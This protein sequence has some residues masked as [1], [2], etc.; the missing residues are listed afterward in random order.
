MSEVNR[1]AE[2]T[3][4]AETVRQ[5]LDYDIHT[6]LFR[7]KT[8]THPNWRRKVGA[9]AGGIRKSGYVTI[10][11]YGRNYFAHRLAWLYVN[12]EWPANII[13]HIDNC[14]SN[15]AFLNLR[16]A[17]QNQNSH[18]S[19]V[20][21]TNT[22]GFKGVTWDKRKRKWQAAIKVKGKSMFLGLYDQKEL[23]FSAANAARAKYHGDFANAGL[24]LTE[25]RDAEA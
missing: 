10:Q 14:R 8:G 6:G 4:T 20:P 22:S 5:L 25:T 12:G 2:S 19:G 11:I 16:E 18:N 3:L 1:S 7:W 23:A 17:N 13:D 9:V 24:P 21:K 15:N